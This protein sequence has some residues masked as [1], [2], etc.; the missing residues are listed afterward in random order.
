MPDISTGRVTL[1]AGVFMRSPEP[2]PTSTAAIIQ[3]WNVAFEQ[4]LPW[5]ISAEIAYVG[6]ATDGGYA[7]LNIN[8]GEPGGGNASRKYF[9]VAG[10][11]AINDWALAHQEPLQGP[12]AR[13]Q[14]PVPQRPD[15][16]GRLHAQPRRRTWRTRTAGSGSPGT[17][18]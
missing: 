11:T 12:A 18:R 16:E 15:A 6:T 17:T 3:Q 1:P 4:R 7:D 2:G 8:Y 9:A 14:P 13:P 5:D 10:T